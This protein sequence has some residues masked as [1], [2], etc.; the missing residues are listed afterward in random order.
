MPVMDG[1]EATKHIRKFNK[2]IPIIAQTAFAE[3][4]DRT[5]ALAAGCNDYQVKTG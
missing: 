3:H 2:A 1:L 5:K 4:E